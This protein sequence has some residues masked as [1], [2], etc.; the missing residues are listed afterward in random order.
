M[1]PRAHF[2]E[3][4]A[5][6]CTVV[7]VRG[8]CWRRRRRRRGKRKK[9]RKVGIFVKVADVKFTRSLSAQNIIVMILR[10]NE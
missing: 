1:K 8:S 3:P 9:R 4:S 2:T 7:F 6:E 10:R 5:H